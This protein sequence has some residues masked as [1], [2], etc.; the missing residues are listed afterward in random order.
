MQEFINHREQSRRDRDRGGW[1]GRSRGRREGKE[2][3]EGK[4]K[5][6][7]VGGA[8]ARIEGT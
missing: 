2:V 5:E 8:N 1:R 7:G 3:G 6:V 4:V